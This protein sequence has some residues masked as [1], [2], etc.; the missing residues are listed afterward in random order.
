MLGITELFH[1]GVFS[2]GWGGQRETLNALCKCSNVDF[3]FL[4]INRPKETVYYAIVKTLS[5]QKHF[6]IVAK[7]KEENFTHKYLNT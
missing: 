4:C 7:C 6:I 1:T 5:F 2:L 3:G